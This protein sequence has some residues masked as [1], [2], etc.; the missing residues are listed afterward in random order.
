MFTY[1]FH[2]YFRADEAWKAWGNEQIDAYTF[3]HTPRDV[4]TRSMVTSP[5]YSL[6]PRPVIIP[7]ISPTSSKNLK[8]GQQRHTRLTLVAR[9]REDSLICTAYHQAHCPVIE[10]AITHSLSFSP[11]SLT[12]RGQ[13]CPLS[14]ACNLL[15]G[16][17]P[18]RGSWKTSAFQPSNRGV[19]RYSCRVLCEIRSP[20]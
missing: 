3:Q 4:Y 10:I 9:E 20:L 12:A 8:R 17:S 16:R 1:L 15:D 13:E 6:S 2:E 11:L 7:T 19:I 18:R 14:R 5:P